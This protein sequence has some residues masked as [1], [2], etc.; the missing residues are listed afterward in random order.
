MRWVICLSTG[1][2]SWPICSSFALFVPSL[3][4]FFSF[5]AWW[6]Y[7]SR[8]DFCQEGDI[9][10]K[11]CF[12]FFYRTQIILLYEIL[13]ENI[14]ALFFNFTSEPNGRVKGTV[15]DHHHVPLV[16]ALVGDFVP[17]QKGFTRREDHVFASCRL[18]PRIWWY[19]SFIQ[20]QY[21]LQRQVGIESI[22]E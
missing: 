17:Q 1:T 20:F 16:P 3:H 4:I 2:R 5:P 11:T 9:Q 18:L 12:N 15:Q 19:V 8:E 10:K 21:L 13:Y 7:N 14:T 6:N 22:N